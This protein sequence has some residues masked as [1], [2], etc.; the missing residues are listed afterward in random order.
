MKVS[1]TGLDLI[2]KHEGL[3]L[4]AYPDPAT[5]GEPWTI[6]YGIT[7]SAGVGKIT[8][9]MR[10]TLAEAEDMLRRALM[11]YE[12]GVQDTLTRRPTQNQFDAMV[13]LAYNIGVPAFRKSSVARFFN[14][15]EIDKAA[16]A[17]LMWNKAA[18]KVMPGLTKRRASEREWFLRPSQP[19]AVPSPATPPPPVTPAPV[20]PAQTPVPMPDLPPDT[21]RHIAAWLIGALG[22]LFAVFAAWM[23]K[24][25]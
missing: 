1:A 14:A 6:G 7:S 8:K 24:G 9:G 11:V 10:I 21:G 22:L 15:G 13:S 17:F 16:G 25:S 12:R 4:T 18:G 3:R 23:T 2:K 20:P 19:A 5:G